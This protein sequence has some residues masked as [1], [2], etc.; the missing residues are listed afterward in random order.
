VIE[1]KAP[2]EAFEQADGGVEALLEPWLVAEGDAVTAGEP[3]ADAIVVKTSF[4]VCAPCDG[5]IVEIVVPKGITFAVGA[6]LARL[7]ASAGVGSGTTGTAS[8]EQQ[9]GA[10]GVGGPARVP[11]T[12]IRGAVARE[13]A[14]AWQHPRVAVGVEVEM[15]SALAALEAQRG[16]GARMSP[17]IAVL[18][19]VALALVE[20]PRLNAVGRR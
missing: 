9:I 8:L 17:T 1:I 15:T 16:D 7:E 10:A 12:G 19:A 5:T 3:V 4:Q 11:L 13:M 6:V 14:S 20:H 18:R 2:A